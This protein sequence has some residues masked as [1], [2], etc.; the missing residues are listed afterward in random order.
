MSVRPP[1]LVSTLAFLVLG[2]SV[3]YPQ[4]PPL[5]RA[6]LEYSPAASVDHP[7]SG[8]FEDGLSVG[9]LN[10]RFEVNLPVRLGD[11]AALVNGLIYSYRHLDYTEGASTGRSLFTSP[12]ATSAPG[13][14]IPTSCSNQGISRC[15]RTDGSG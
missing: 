5:L 2:P 9:V 1:L 11:G 14:E 13:A 15:W 7:D 8:T 10:P 6:T 3:V 4:A 12:R